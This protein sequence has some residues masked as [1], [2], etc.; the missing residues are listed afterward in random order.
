MEEMVKMIKNLYCL[1]WDEWNGGNILYLLKEEE[2][3]FFL[4]LI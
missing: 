2:I 1:G 4:N 3:L